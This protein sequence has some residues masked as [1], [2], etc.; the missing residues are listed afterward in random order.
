MHFP[1]TD[2]IIFLSL[3]Y[4]FLIGWQKGLL[5]TLIGPISFIA[6]SIFSY[7]YYQQTHNLIVSLLIGTLGPIVIHILYSIFK[8]LTRDKNKKETFELSLPR[9][10][11]GIIHASWSFVMLTLCLILIIGGKAQS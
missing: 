9:I 10:L 2:I 5:D 3:L 7:I 6:T 8:N 4:H 11:A 1:I